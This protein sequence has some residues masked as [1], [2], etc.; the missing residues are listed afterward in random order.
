MEAI[1]RRMILANLMLTKG[2]EKSAIDVY[3][4]LL[5]STLESSIHCKVLFNLAQALES[6]AQNCAKNNDIE[7]VRKYRLEAVQALNQCIDVDKTFHEAYLNLSGLYL[8][9]RDPQRSLDQAL[10]GISSLDSSSQVS[11]HTQLLT[12]INVAMR[13]LGKRKEAVQ[14][15]WREIGLHYDV[16]EVL[17]RW[18]TPISSTPSPHPLIIVCVKYGKK[19]S[20]DYVNNLYNMIHRSWNPSVSSIVQRFRMTCLTDDPTGIARENIQVLPLEPTIAEEATNLPG[21]WRK[22]HVFNTVSYCPEQG[23]W[24]MY[25]DLDTVI[26]DFSLSQVMDKL[27]LSQSTGNPSSIYV[28]DSQT[29]RNEGKLVVNEQG[30]IG[31]LLDIGYCVLDR[32]TSGNKFFD[33]HLFNTWIARIVS[34]Y[35]GQSYSSRKNFQV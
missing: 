23:E 19:Y 28:L 6:C 2:R 10:A 22:I 27:L 3:H 14:L 32:E 35:Y 8:K 15:T 20:A 9:L 13:Q 29:F 24:V 17:L 5:E 12:N 18:L 4:R 25:I 1:E 30:F 7:D 31:D 33:Y 34:V 26:A 16:D 11:L 21:W